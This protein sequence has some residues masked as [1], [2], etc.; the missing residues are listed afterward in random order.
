MMKRIEDELNYRY[1][2]KKKEDIRKTRGFSSFFVSKK[3]S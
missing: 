2:E 3:D 1:S